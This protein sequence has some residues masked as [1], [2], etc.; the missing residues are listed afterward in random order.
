M[1]RWGIIYSFGRWRTQAEIEFENP[2]PADKVLIVKT[3]EVLY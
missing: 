3:F 1:F 2:P